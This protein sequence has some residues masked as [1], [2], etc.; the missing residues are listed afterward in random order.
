MNSV[1]FV[2]YIIMM[3]DILEPGLPYQPMATTVLRMFWKLYFEMLN[4]FVTHSILYSD[5][6]SL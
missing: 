1:S 6:V 3:G 2:S 4:N 5:V